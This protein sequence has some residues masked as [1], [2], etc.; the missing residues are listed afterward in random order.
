MWCWWCLA[1]TKWPRTLLSSSVHF[2]LKFI[3]KSVVTTLK[4]RG[5]CHA[6]STSTYSYQKTGGGEIKVNVEKF[7]QHIVLSEIGIKKLSN[8]VG[9]LFYFFISLY[10]LK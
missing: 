6:F 8:I 2:F 5:N 10:F 1:F 3:G 4:P 7:D 9:F